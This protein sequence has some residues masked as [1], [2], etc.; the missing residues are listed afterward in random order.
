[1][2]WETEKN[3]K[4]S[5]TI[6][7]IQAEYRN[8]E[9]WVHTRNARGSNSSTNPFRDTKD[10]WILKPR[11]WQDRYHAHASYSQSLRVQKSRVQYT[12]VIHQHESSAKD[13]PLLPAT[14]EDRL[15]RWSNSVLVRC[16]CRTEAQISSSNAGTGRATARQDIS[17][18]VTEAFSH[19][20][21]RSRHSSK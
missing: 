9:S 4:N 5:V 18:L 17:G 1:M 21:V 20:T 19:L 11:H 12:C 2:P 14:V 10:P 6:A 8:W 15:A 3:T 7:G 13:R 16:T